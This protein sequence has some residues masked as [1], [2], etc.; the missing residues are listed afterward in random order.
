[1]ASESQ[2]LSQVR[3]AECD[4]AGIIYHAHVFDWFSEA[5]IAWLKEHHL[6]YY[7]VLR[8]RSIELLVKT[9][10]ASFHHT[11]RPGDPIRI[12]V[13]A[14]ELSPTRVTFHYRV[15]APANPEITAIEGFTEHAFVVENRAKRLDRTAPDILA[16]FERAI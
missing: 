7:D 1:M 5:R 8:A 2:W 15:T 13:T 12:V 11:L 4:A 6:D 9:A 10:N 16:Q 3:W 14:G